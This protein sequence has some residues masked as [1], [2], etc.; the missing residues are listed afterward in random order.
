MR[1]MSQHFSTSKI[2]NTKIFYGEHLNWCNQIEKN[3]T[4][5]IYLINYKDKIVGYIIS[6]FRC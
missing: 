5:L 2:T 1:N 3:N 4:D 6:S